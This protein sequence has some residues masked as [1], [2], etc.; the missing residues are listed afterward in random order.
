[1]KSIRALLLFLILLITSVSSFSQVVINEIM[2]NPPDVIGNDD[3]FEWI[4]LYNNS[5][6]PIDVSGW[7]LLDDDNSHSP[8]IM[9]VG[10][11]ISANGFLVIGKNVDSVSAFYKIGRASCRERV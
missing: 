7:R 2:Y 11:I 1:M 9:P 3:F 10:T 4:E 5:T 6:S 8:F